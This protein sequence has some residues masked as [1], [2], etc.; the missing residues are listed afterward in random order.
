LFDHPEA[1]PGTR[2]ALGRKERFEYFGQIVFTNSGA[3]VGKLDLNSIGMKASSCL[4]AKHTPLQHC[5]DGVRHNVGKDLHQFAS[6]RQQERMVLKST[7]GC[8]AGGCEFALIDGEDIFNKVLNNYR[9]WCAVISIVAEALPR[10]LRHA[11]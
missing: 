10:N 2:I 11:L 3:I 4:N 5:V 6:A 8:D 9:S 7:F 1:N